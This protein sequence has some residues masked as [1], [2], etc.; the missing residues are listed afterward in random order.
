LVPYNPEYFAGFRAEGF[1]IDLDDGFTEAR[2]H[3]DRVIARDVRFDIGG[4]ASGYTI[5]TPPYPMSG[6]NISYCPCG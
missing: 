4:I 1:T 5:S 2:A 6:S 3:M